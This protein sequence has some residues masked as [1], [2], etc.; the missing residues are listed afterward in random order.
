[1]LEIHE[2]PMSLGKV[3]K[4]IRRHTDTCCKKYGVTAY[5]YVLLCLLA[6]DDGVTQQVLVERA[7]S[8]PNTIRAMLVLLEKKGMVKRDPNISD[9]R[10]R[11]VVLTKK[12]R[13]T[14]EKAFNDIEPVSKHIY[15]ALS[16]KELKNIL[17]ILDR[18]L[19]SMDELNLQDNA[20]QKDNIHKRKK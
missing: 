12:G 19:T 5:Q 10:R 7:Y 18:I 6:E 20:D 4:A 17:K 13:K 8:D 16:D 15:K 2:L 3:S 11:H 14:Y 1:M 9:V